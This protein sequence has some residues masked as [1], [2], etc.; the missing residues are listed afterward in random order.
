MFVEGVDDSNCH[1]LRGYW[2]THPQKK[3]TDLDSLAQFLLSTQDGV[4]KQNQ[5]LANFDRP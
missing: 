4:A 5:T 1:S 2:A 3:L